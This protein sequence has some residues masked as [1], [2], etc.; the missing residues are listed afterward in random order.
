MVRVHVAAPLHPTE[1]PER[2]AQAVGAFWPGAPVIGDDAVTLE[3]DHLAAFRERIWEL[4]I[5]DTARGQMLHRCDGATTNVWLSKQAAMHNKINFPPGEHALGNVVVTITVE[6]DDPWADAEELVWWLCPE[7]ADGEIV[8][9]GQ[10][11]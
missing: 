3:S 1:V 4:R 5:I 11:S 10:G 8:P 7:T 2:V 6:D 9:G